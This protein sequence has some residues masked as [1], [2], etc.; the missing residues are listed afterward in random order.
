M[1]GGNHGGG[2]S[3]PGSSHDVGHETAVMPNMQKKSSCTDEIEK[4][5]NNREE[6]RK[7]MEDIKN[8]REKRQ[9]E[10]EAHGW[11]VDVDF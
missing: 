6:R 10:N 4:I 8:N 3:N 1:P 2:H 11:K 5:K 9:A 7:R